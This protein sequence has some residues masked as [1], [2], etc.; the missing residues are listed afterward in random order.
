MPAQRDGSLHSFNKEHDSSREGKPF[1]DGYL[2]LRGYT[3]TRTFDYELPDGSLLYQQNRYDHTK[4]LR[5]GVDQKKKQFLPSRPVRPD[6]FDRKN[7]IGESVFGPGERRI[8]YNWPAIMRAGPGSTVFITEGETNSADLI[9][10]GLL[11]TTVISHK[12]TT[13]CAA[14]LTGRDLIILEDNDADG[15]ELAAKAYF[16]LSKVAESI[17]IVPLKHLWKRISDK[18]PPEAGDVT[19]WINSGGDPAKL[20][21]ICSETPAEGV[22]IAEPHSFPEESTLERLDFLYGKHLLRGEVS[23]TAALGSTGKSTQSI[24]QALSMASGKALTHDAVPR[25]LRVVLIN[26]EDRR[27]IMDKRIAAAMR[28]HKLT[29]E[30]IGDRLTVIAKGELKIKVARQ[31]RP[32]SIERDELI[33]RALTNLMVEK[34]ADVLSV[35]S[36]IRTHA[37]NENDNSAIQEAVECFEDIADAADC[38]IHLWHH[39]RKENGQGATIDS[40]RGARAFVDACRSVRVLEVMSKEEGQRLKIENYKSFFRSFS[41]KL[42]FAPP[43]EQSDWFKL[44]SIEID[45]GGALFGDNIGVVEAWQHP[46]TTEVGLT[47]G[48]VNAIKR[49]VGEEPRWRED[50]RA[51]MWVGK[52]V[53]KVLELDP[54]DDRETVKQVIK[55]MLKSGAL[56]TELGPDEDRRERMFIVANQSAP[57]H[58]TGAEKTRPEM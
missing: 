5:P 8:I 27:S 44:V 16:I 17:R 30:D 19:D 21:D 13:E 23:G 42:N 20:T 12:W 54:E 3:L 26:L 53:A 6:L 43:V 4:D 14:A 38:A 2:K 11:A 10:T 35:D 45:N 55:R 22:I 1:D 51:G 31:S 32:G 18:E 15:R 48:T 41:G 25:P 52:A 36:F 9:K 28:H 33:I 56:K 47:L 29:K 40:A 50:V 34:K 58:V 39:S 24:V 46:G 49:E 37:V 7:N 57:V